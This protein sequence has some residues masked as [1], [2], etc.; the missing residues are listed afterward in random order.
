MKYKKTNYHSHT[1]RCNHAVGEDEQYVLKAIENGYDLIGFSD[2]IMLPWTNTINGCRG[3]FAQAEDY[4]QSVHRLQQ[5]YKDQIKILLAY[6]CEWHPNFVDYYQSLLDNHIVDYLMLGHHFL[7][8]DFTTGEFSNP[9]K[10]DTRE[11]A[12][13]YLKTAIDALNSG[14]FKIFAHPDWFM[15]FFNQWDEE[16]ALLAK[17]MCITAKKNNVALEINQGCLINE[18]INTYAEIL[19]EKRYRYPYS[20]FWQI[21]SEVQNV[22]ITNLDAHRPEAYDNQ[23][24]K[25]FVDSFVK[26]HHLSLTTDLKI[27]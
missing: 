25:E 15:G 11:Y 13:F 4:Y 5:K 3:V 7:D 26:K 20:P 2:H 1:Y 14:L 23:Q 22:V 17:E 10:N 8:Y 19:H 27:K 24:A 12:I 18:T 16:I 9:C 6:E 21:V